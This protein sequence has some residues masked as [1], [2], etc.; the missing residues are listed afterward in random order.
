MLS[1][2]LTGLVLT[3][4]WN[5]AKINMFKETGQLTGIFF[6]KKTGKDTDTRHSY[7]FRIMYFF[8]HSSF[9]DLCASKF[10]FPHQFKLLPLY[11]AILGEHNYITNNKIFY[12]YLCWKFS[13]TSYKSFGTGLKWNQNCIRNIPTRC[14]PLSCVRKR[15]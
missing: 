13:A 10:P 14:S 6:Q 15:D 8:L 2:V 9:C 12:V 1:A 7:T 4:I 5:F 11:S 3:E